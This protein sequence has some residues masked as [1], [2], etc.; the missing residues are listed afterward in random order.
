VLFAITEG[1]GLP[2][3]IAQRVLEILVLSF[4]PFSFI[5]PASG[6]GD[7]SDEWKGYKR[8]GARDS[9]S[10]VL[11]EFREDWITL[12]CTEDRELP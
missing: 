3:C 10:H 12:Y 6:N 11:L 9:E 8:R 1:C 4:F 5:F 7:C 2:T